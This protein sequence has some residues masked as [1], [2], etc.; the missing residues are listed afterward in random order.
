METPNTYSLFPSINF[1]IVSKTFPCLIVLL[2]QALL[3]I[4][5][6][7]LMEILVL[8]SFVNIMINAPVHL[9]M[10]DAN[11]ISYNSQSTNLDLGI[12]NGKFVR[13][14][15]LSITDSM[16]SSLMSLSLTL[17]VDLILFAFLT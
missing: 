10:P 7:L 11:F 13:L 2:Y 6:L 4:S 3:Y 5:S 17:N 9:L 8:D 14:V 12:F 16:Y 15:A 1:Q